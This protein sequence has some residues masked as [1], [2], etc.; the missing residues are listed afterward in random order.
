MSESFVPIRQLASAPIS[1]IMHKLVQPAPHVKSFRNSSDQRSQNQSVFF[2]AGPFVV[3]LTMVSGDPLGRF[4]GAGTKT[5]V[6]FMANS[7]HRQE[8]IRS[9][10]PSFWLR[11]KPALASD[12]GSGRVHAS[13]KKYN[14]IVRLICKVTHDYVF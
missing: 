10:C 1:L 8:R 7:L 11:H 2:R 13:S 3:M 12:S 6:S 4:F 9:S 5:R 14:L